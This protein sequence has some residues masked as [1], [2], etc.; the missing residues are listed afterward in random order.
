VV[1]NLDEV[2]GTL[3]VN[4]IFTGTFGTLTISVVSDE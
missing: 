4:A 3:S 2:G 1:G